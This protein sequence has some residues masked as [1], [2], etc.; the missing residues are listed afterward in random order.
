MK[1]NLLK[2]RKLP[3]IAILAFSVIVYF[4]YGEYFSLSFIQDQR[5]NFVAYQQSYPMLTALL[6]LG[7]Y[8]IATGLSLPFGTVL[9]ILGGF[10]FGIWWGLLIVT[11]GATI[12]ATAIFLVSKYSLKGVVP[13]RYE[14][15]YNKV[16]KNFEEND[17]SYLFFLR[18]VPLFPFALVN[19]LPALFNV[20]TRIYIYTTF[21]GIIPGTFAHTYLGSAFSQITSLEGLISPQ[22]IS[23]SLIPIFIK[24]YKH[25]KAQKIG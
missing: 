14:A 23:A 22:V 25:K 11:L 17:I 18:L 4:L 9:A 6:F 20:P 2:N 7:M 24:W 3:L 12:G 16:K 10:L 1:K 13:K 21:I 19:I 15:P 8:A 5:E